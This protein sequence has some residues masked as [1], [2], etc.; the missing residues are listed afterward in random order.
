MGCLRRSR[1]RTP[2]W[3]KAETFLLTSLP[4][5]HMGISMAGFAAYT[6]TQLDTGMSLYTT[7]AT[8]EEILHANNN[9][10][11]SGQTVRFFPA[12]TYNQPSLHGGDNFG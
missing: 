2:C 6:L 5:R 9:L 11:Q 3:K 1:V 12:G 10:K 4:F 8:Q 7:I